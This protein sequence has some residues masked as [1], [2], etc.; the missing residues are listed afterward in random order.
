MNNKP[1]LGIFVLWHPSFKEGQEYADLIFSEFKRNVNAPLARGMNIPVYFRYL[2]PLL[3]I[4]FDEHDFTVTIALIDASFVLDRDFRDYLSKASKASGRS[5]LIPVAIDK[6]AFNVRLGNINMARLYERVNKKEYLISI[7]AHEVVKHLYDLKEIIDPTDPSPKPLK[8]FLS[9]AKADGVEIAKQLKVYIE[10]QLPLKTFFDANDISIA[11]DF[12][13]EIEH[14]IK[15]AVVIALHTDQYSSREWCRREILLAKEHNRPIVILNCF[16]NGESRSFPY[17]ANV[18]TVHY[19][20]L[21]N[22]DQLIT[23]VMKETLRLKYMKLW[24]A[25]MAQLKRPGQ[26]INEDSISGYPPELVTILRKRDQLKNE[27]I[28][29]EPSLGSEE[30][31]IL[32]SLDPS[33]KYLTPADL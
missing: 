22:W 11:Y 20:N 8:L 1:P 27:F 19:T 17:M 18:L 5:L 15:K 25:Y 32:K 28:Y 30:L 14:H 3:D 12:S 13:K 24:I 21:I 29:P 26:L 9:H 2:K 10:S 31:E 4:P 7:I 23:A 33:I 16:Q 6:A